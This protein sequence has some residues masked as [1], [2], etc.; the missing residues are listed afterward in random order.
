M[1][2]IG[3]IA[4]VAFGLGLAVLA[5]LAFVLRAIF[6]RQESPLAD[7]TRMVQDMYRVL[8]RLE[9][10]VAVLES[11]LGEQRHSKGSS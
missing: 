4:L 10:R 9:E 7:E 8:T 2:A 6:T 11:L 3:V 5:V 1:Q